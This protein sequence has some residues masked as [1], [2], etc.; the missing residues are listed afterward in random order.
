[1]KV[2]SN[3][4]EYCQRRLVLQDFLKINEDDTKPNKEMQM[5]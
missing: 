4:T 2:Y 1:M 3:N 5:L